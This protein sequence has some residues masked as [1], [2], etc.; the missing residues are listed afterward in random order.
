MQV[1]IIRTWDPR[2]AAAMTH[3]ILIGPGF[4]SRVAFLERRAP[5]FPLNVAGFGIMSFKETRDVKRIAARAHQ[6]VVADDNWRRRREVLLLH[7]GDLFMPALLSGQ[8]I[9]RN[10]VVIRGLEKEPPS[11]HAHSPIADVNA[12]LGFPGVVPYFAPSAGID[13]PCVV[14]R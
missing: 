1:R 9:E 13:R 2:H 10:K 5:P 14:R 8:R 11:I 4:K 3:G 7:I 12:A 6:D